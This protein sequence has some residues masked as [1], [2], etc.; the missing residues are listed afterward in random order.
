MIAERFAI[1]GLP[2][3]ESKRCTL[4]PG[5]SISPASCSKP[6]VALTKS[7]SAVCEAT[8]SSVKYAWIERHQRQWPVTLQ[9]EVPGVIALLA[10]HAGLAALADDAE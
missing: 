7:R 8:G 2:E 9:C 5:L 3:A 6:T 1:V 10:G 4:L